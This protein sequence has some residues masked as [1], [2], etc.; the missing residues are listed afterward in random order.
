[1][2][3]ISY[4]IEMARRKNRLAIAE[5]YLTFIGILYQDQIESGHKRISDFKNMTMFDIEDEIKLRTK[6]ITADN[7][8][9]IKKQQEDAEK[10]EKQLL[11]HLKKLQ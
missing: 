6:I 10:R 1:M 5:E 8:R 2:S 9:K 4:K 11:D 7:A 3:I